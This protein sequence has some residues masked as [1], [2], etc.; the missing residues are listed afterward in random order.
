MALQSSMLHSNLL[1]GMP[2]GLEA[3]LA[4]HRP[5]NLTPWECLAPALQFPFCPLLLIPT[6]PAL[7]P[8]AATSSC[9]LLEDHSLNLSCSS[10]KPS[11]QVLCENGLSLASSQL[12]PA[13]PPAPSV[14]W[15]WFSFC[16][17]SFLLSP[18]QAVPAACCHLLC[19]SFLGAANKST[20]CEFYSLC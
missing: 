13:H 7:S 3:V 17:F 15:L 12:Q 18:G 8:S 1:S 4:F 20:S 9:Q 10:K 5:L 19:T 2:E 14:S 11:L 16:C 6:F